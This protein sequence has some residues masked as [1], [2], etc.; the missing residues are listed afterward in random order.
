MQ[1]TSISHFLF[2]QNLFTHMASGYANLLE[3]LR[4]GKRA[5]PNY[6]A[7]DVRE[8]LLSTKEA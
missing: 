5:P 1:N 8:R 4:N 3:Q 7:M 2:L 6:R